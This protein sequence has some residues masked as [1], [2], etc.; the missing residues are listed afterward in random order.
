MPS[1][2]RQMASST[3]V[4]RSGM[5]LY[6]CERRMFEDVG[7]ESLADAIPAKL[8]LKD[9]DKNVA[10]R[11]GLKEQSESFLPLCKASGDGKVQW[12]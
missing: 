11:L 9:N 2:E 6:G 3:S 12:R 4:S 7:P 10:I 5:P 1:T 8:C